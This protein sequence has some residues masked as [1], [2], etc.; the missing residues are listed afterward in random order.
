MK[1]VNINRNLKIIRYIVILFAACSFFWL[2]RVL[3][4]VNFPDFNTNYYAAINVI[5]NIDPYS[6]SVN[7]FTPQVYPPFDIIFYIPLGILPFSFASKIWIILSIAAVALTIYLTAK[8][9]KISLLSTYNILLMGLICLSFPLKF[10]LGMGQLNNVILGFIAISF[11]YLN[12]KKHIYS[13]FILAFPILLKFFPLL[14]IPYFVYIRRWKIVIAFI[15]SVICFM[16]LTCILLTFPVVI[17][18]FQNILPELL[19]SWKGDYY[20]QSLSGVLIRIF[21]DRILSNYLRIIISLVLLLITLFS[22]FVFKQ[23]SQKRINLEFAAILTLSVLINNFSWQHHFVFLLLPYLIVLYTL[24]REK[25]SSI[26]YSALAI[27]YIL[28][29]LNSKNPSTLHVLLQ[30]HVFF[31]G[32]LL[33]LLILYLLFKYKL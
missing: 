26:F 14:I 9:Y 6:T 24:Y 28:I 30:N 16:L 20:N 10:T 23:K 15:A 27:S 21:P 33:W 8:I 22:I 7:Y 11:Y 17:N 32:L 4:N 29:S 25:V 1:K 5:N 13:G 18:Y 12:T 19:S 31:G 3:L 2:L